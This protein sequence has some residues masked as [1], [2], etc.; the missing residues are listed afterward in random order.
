[1]PLVMNLSKERNK[2]IV[3]KPYMIKNA[4]R[5]A[6]TAGYDTVGAMFEG[7]NTSKLQSLVDNAVKSDSWKEAAFWAIAGWYSDNGDDA[8][9]KKFKDLSFAMTDKRQARE[10]LGEQTEK[11]KDN[12]L[13]TAELAVL[14]DNYK[15]YKT[16]EQMWIY[17][18]LCFITMQPVLRTSTYSSLVIAKKLKDIKDDDN[19]YIYYSKRGKWSGHFYINDDKV[20]STFTH[21]DSKKILIRDPALLKIIDASV[22]AYPRP[23]GK[24]FEINILKKDDKM[25][26]LLRK[27]TSTIGKPLFNFD[28]ARSAFI[29]SIPATASRATRKSLARSMRHTVE[30]QDRNYKKNISVTE[31][32][33]QAELDA[34]DKL[35]LEQAHKILQLERALEE[36]A[37]YKHDWDERRTDVVRKANVA[38]ATIRNTTLEKYGIV[39]KEGK[40]E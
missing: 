36:T 24:I 15:D 21:K 40:Y 33:K 39:K 11:E 14:R 10:D 27:A 25:L 16:E 6:K 30:T 7:M 3:N 29:N 1:M 20:S 35:I 38:K 8:F 17:L 13:S 32:A 22:V 4:E 23:N 26:A 31:P 12:Y 18:I 34:K 2:P 28:M 37:K 19:N 9:A 5:L